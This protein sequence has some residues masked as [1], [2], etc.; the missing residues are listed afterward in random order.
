MTWF[1]YLCKVSMILVLCWALYQ[2]ALRRLTFFQ[3]NRAYL[4][5]SVVLS[6]LL[7]LIQLQFDRSVVSV[8]EI[9]GIDWQFMES[10]TATGGSS[11]AESRTFRWGILL[12]GGYFAVVAVLLY[13][14]I[15][16]F[17]LMSACTRQATMVRDGK[18]RIY[19][20]DS[21]R[22]SFTLF[23]RIY[24][25]T[26]SY[27]NSSHQVLQH[28]M[29]HASQLH[30]I[31][32]LFME[33]VC[34]VLWFNPF[35][36][37]LRRRIRENHEY[38]ADRGAC[39]A[40]PN[41][42]DY[43]VCLRDE[44]VRR[45]SPAIASNFKSSTIKKRIIMLTNKKSKST[46]KWRYL[47]A[48]PLLAG[49]ILLFQSPADEANGAPVLSEVLSPLNSFV[50]GSI[51]DGGTPSIFPLPLKYEEKITWGFTEA[52]HPFTGKMTKHNG[53]DIAAPTGTPVFATADGKVKKAE[54]QD[55]WGN[56]VILEHAGGFATVYAHMDSFQVKSGES[57]T[58]GQVIGKV[59]N[60]GQSTGPHLHYEVR[61]NG[62]F[63]DPANYY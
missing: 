37:L 25:D 21:D 36:F 7:P 54:L 5:G 20:L 42:V 9:Q 11:E 40:Q 32:L 45:Y 34:I 13:F 43:L 14:T 38:I 51:L 28:E 16:R 22:G 12:P 39:M 6:L 61:K 19:V 8:A 2:A 30:S 4:L 47:A 3:W 15:R 17:R 23:R 44:T 59:G 52:K 10:F 46:K 33:F 63:Q 48:L 35:V 60:T 53:I 57:V 1:V 58:K 18:V 55:G 41:P 62:E 27:K 31:D 56:L 50:A 29:I 24:L 26:Y 49:M